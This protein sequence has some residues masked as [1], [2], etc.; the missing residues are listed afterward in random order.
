MSKRTGSIL[1]MTSILSLA[2]LSACPTTEEPTNLCGNGTID[3]G[4]ACDGDALGDK[5]CQTEGHS[6]GDM[7][8]NADCQLDSSACVDDFYPDGPYGTATGDIV[9]DLSYVPANLASRELAG[10][11]GVFSLSDLYQL[12]E[13][14]GG[15]YRGVMLFITT[16]WCV[17]CPIESRQLEALYQ[18]MKD[19]GI[20]LMGLVL[21][22]NAGRP[23]TPA[24]ADAYANHYG[25]TFPAFAGQLPLSYWQDGQGGTPAH[26][27]FDLRNMRVYGRAA[28]LMDIKMLRYALQDL[29]RGPEWDA[30]GERNIS[31]DIA[32]GTGSEVEPNGLNGTP[33]DGSSLPADLSGVF[34]PPAI[35]EG[36]SIDEDVIDLGTLH[37]GDVID[38]SISSGDG[39]PTFPFFELVRLNAT[40]TNLEGS[41]NAPSKLAT[42]TAGRQIVIDATGH[43]L[44]AAVEGRLMA[45]AHYGQSTP[46]DNMS[47]CEGGPEYTYS[48]SI[49]S[50]GLEATESALTLGTEV[51]GRLDMNDTKVFPVEV[52]NGQSYVF[53]LKSSSGDKMD[54]YLVLYDPS[55]NSV[56]DFN[57]DEDNANE[58]YDSK[59]TW[60]ADGDKT[61]WLVAQYWQALFDSSAPAF[62]IKVAA[63]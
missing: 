10:E 16:G 33:A 36:L 25:W 59:I 7:A 22:N 17:Y 60:T 55:D 14:H 20:L 19:Q 41:T 42:G 46:P 3:E 56:I 8:C 27:F 63:E 32:P 30:N 58:K 6:Y 40:G 1:A 54:P 37:A 39:S 62:K 29:A 11:D 35:A 21:E 50:Y 51:T 24:D 18:E 53:T 9:E 61:V 15:Q 45:S 48:F 23:A 49:S 38:L 5:T 13:Q 4:E 44:A 28:G 34:G 26:V 43:Y 31:F 12:N 2:L 57:D 47:C 52:S